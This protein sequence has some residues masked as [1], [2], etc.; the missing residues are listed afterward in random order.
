MFLK[1]YGDQA[2]PIAFKCRVKSNVRLHFSCIIVTYAVWS[3]FCS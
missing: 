2:E 3:S 1:V